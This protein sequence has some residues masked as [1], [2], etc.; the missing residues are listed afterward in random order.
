MGTKLCEAGLDALNI[1]LG[2][3][4]RCPELDDGLILGEPDSEGAH[5]AGRLGE[6]ETKELVAGEHLHVGGLVHAHAVGAADEA[7]AGGEGGHGGVLAALVVGGVFGS[8]GVADAGL[9]GQGHASEDVGTG[10]AVGADGALHA[11]EHLSLDG[12]EAGLDATDVP[13]GL[14]LSCPELD[15]GLV[16]GEPDSEGAHGAGLLG[17]LET[18]EL[19]AGEHLH[20]LGL[21][22]AHAVGAA[23]KAN[24]GGEGGH[25]GVLAA[26]VVGGV[27]GSGG[28]ADASLGSQGHA[29]E[30]VGAGEAVGGDGALHPEEHLRWGGHLD[31]D[32]VEVAGGI[33][34]DGH[35]SDGS[36]DDSNHTGGSHR[37]R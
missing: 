4:L 24:A 32:G 27:L 25:G 23:D 16:L 31:A 9:G 30:D 29:S 5:G 34:A 18:K 1:P 26:G 3:G 20:V 13:L 14:G 19:V 28:V 8:G 6:L 37:I 36:H 35:Q 15:D 21:V 22:H 2:L 11:S 12:G 33:A 10:E 17:E 7:N